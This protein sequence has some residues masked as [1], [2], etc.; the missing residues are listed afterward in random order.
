MSQSSTGQ[1]EKRR[2]LDLIQVLCLILLI[3]VLHAP[4][5]ATLNRLKG[6]VEETNRRVQEVEKKLDELVAQQR[7]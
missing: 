3:A 2:S 4:M 1:S 6:Q 5:I 7:P